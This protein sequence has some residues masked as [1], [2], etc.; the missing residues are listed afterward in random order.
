[1]QDNGSVNKALPENSGSESLR[2]SD[3]RRHQWKCALDPVIQGKILRIQNRHVSLRLGLCN[4]YIVGERDP[5]TF[6][7]SFDL[8]LT[9][10][11]EGYLLDGGGTSGTPV[12]LATQSS[13]PP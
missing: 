8:M 2:F 13:H 10:T 1:M 3:F 9:V 6:S 5:N 4:V 11:V 12:K 7:D